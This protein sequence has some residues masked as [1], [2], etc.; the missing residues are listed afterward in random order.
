MTPF[1]I[2]IPDTA[3]FDLEARLGR[4]R[5]AQTLAGTGW[6]YGIDDGFLRGFLDYWAN[7]Y[8]WRAAETRLNSF[9]QFT[10]VV[11]GQTIHFVHVRGK[12]Q[13]NVPILLTN[14]WPSNFVELL[15]LVPL[16]TEAIDGVAFDVIIPSLP[17]YGFSSQPTAPGM[18]MSAIAPLWAELMTRLGYDKFLISGSDLGTGVETTLVR[19]FPERL[20]GAHY[21]NAFSG[22]PRPADPTPEEQ[23]FLGNADRWAFTE[24]AYVMVHGT[25]PATLA[26]GLNDSPAGLAAWILEKYEPLTATISARSS[27]S[28]GSARPSAARSGS[29]RKPL[30]I[31]A[32]C[33]RYPG[34]ACPRRSL[35]PSSTIRRPAPGAS[36]TSKIWCAGP[37]PSRADI[38]R[39]WKSPRRWPMTSGRF[40]ARSPKLVQR[41][42]FA[43]PCQPSRST[44]WTKPSACL[45]SWMRCVGIVTRSR[46]P[47]WP[48]SRGCRFARSIAMCRRLSGSARPSMARLGSAIC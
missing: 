28:I 6:S 30:A 12:G 48:R 36:A 17:G 4:T 22:L 38:F 37:K 40:T 13:T 16:L 33:S 5:F 35:C 1:T 3:L 31:R 41:V 47:H 19:N 32:C 2:A 43:P 46:P 8:D 27:R 42:G 15:P 39:R 45:P 29:T 11:D 21:I 44:P 14:G 26:V 24:G 9:P 18:S 7:Q 10:E 25:K 23:A 34:T 20:I